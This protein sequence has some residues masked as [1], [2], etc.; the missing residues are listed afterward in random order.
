M[1]RLI[2][3]ETTSR[4]QQSLGRVLPQTLSCLT[5]THVHSRNPPLVTPYSSQSYDLLSLYISFLKPPDDQSAL[6]SHHSPVNAPQAGSAI[7]KLRPTDPLPLVLIFSSPFKIPM[8]SASPCMTQSY[9]PS[10]PS[11]SFRYD[12]HSFRVP[13]QHRRD[14]EYE[15]SVASAQ[16]PHTGSGIRGQLCDRLL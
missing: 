2:D 6:L 3:C 1:P 14:A 11:I 10:C 12:R 4:H 7:R 16:L 5:S 13:D 8:V 15:T 9:V